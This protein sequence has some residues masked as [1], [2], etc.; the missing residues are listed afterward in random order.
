MKWILC[1]NNKPDSK[2][3][4]GARCHEEVLVDD[5]ST[6]A[7]CWKCVARM[8][9]IETPKPKTGYPRGWKFMAEFV[10][11]DG[12]V[13]HKGELQPDLFGSKPATPIKEIKKP[14]RKKKKGDSFDEKVLE[15]MQKRLD[16]K[17]AGKGKSK[18][19]VKATEPTPKTTK[20]TKSRES[21][22]TLDPGKWFAE[23][24]EVTVPKKTTKK[25]VTRKTTTAKSK[26]K[27]VTKPKTTAK[28]TAKKVAKKKTKK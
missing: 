16:K 10:D 15:E 9:P 3:W 26:P 12:N 19:E 1:E 27:K 8:V 18:V 22:K 28:K 25:T 24:S 21:T 11:K 20:K 23:E 13:Y 4:Q 14:V 2:Y 17:R 6:K 7:W 5:H